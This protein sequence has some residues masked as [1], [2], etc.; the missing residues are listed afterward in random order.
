MAVAKS[1]HVP[2]VSVR[3]VPATSRQQLFMS[4]QGMRDMQWDNI[5]FE[6]N[7]E[8]TAVYAQSKLAN[9]LF[10]LELSKRVKCK[11]HFLSILSVLDNRDLMS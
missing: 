3:P 5:M 10:N 2:L 6:G 1:S 8:G 9:I 4:F 7:Y 11:P